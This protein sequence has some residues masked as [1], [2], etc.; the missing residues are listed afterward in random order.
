MSKWFVANEKSFHRYSFDS[1]EKEY[2]NAICDFI[3]NLNGDIIV[4][5]NLMDIET[6]TDSYLILG[7]HRIKLDK[8]IVGYDC[9]Y[10]IFIINDRE[11]ISI[12]RGN[13]ENIIK[14][15]DL[16]M[17]LTVEQPAT[18]ITYQ[19]DKIYSSSSKLVGISATKLY[20]EHVHVICQLFENSDAN[21]G[22]CYCDTMPYGIITN[23]RGETNIIIPIVYLY[24]MII[25]YN[26]QGNYIGMPAFN[27]KYNVAKTNKISKMSYYVDILDVYFNPNILKHIR[28]NKSGKKHMSNILKKDMKL[29]GLT[30]EGEHL[31]FNEQGY[32]YDKKLRVSIPIP[33]Y[34]NINMMSNTT[35]GFK[36]ERTNEKRKKNRKRTMC[37]VSNYE[38]KTIPFDNTVTCDKNIIDYIHIYKL[39]KGEIRDKLMNMYHNNNKYEN[40]TRIIFEDDTYYKYDVVKKIKLCEI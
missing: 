31:T 34:V 30:Y 14:L 24:Q 35:L 3:E 19:D 9:L 11:V 21:N 39:P 23:L 26:K 18:I 22:I 10:T 8:P 38:F 1:D 37:L 29:S 2:N 5:C 40:N 27:F 4:F 13:V 15:C 28:I 32:I 33:I 6:I 7:E 16:K 12:I 20:N 36:V 25:K 17:N